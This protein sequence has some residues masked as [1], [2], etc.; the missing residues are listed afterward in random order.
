V[1][2]ATGLFST[3]CLAAA[4]LCSSH[5]AGADAYPAFRA[6]GLLFGDAYH[7]PSHHSEAGDGATGLVLRRGYLTFN[8]DFS[9]SWF[10]RLRF[11]LNQSR[12]V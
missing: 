4:L 10:G 9:D 12:D 3:A 11:E 6:G 5:A 2:R 1:R 7:V 8:A